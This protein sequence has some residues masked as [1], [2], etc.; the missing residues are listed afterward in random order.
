[1]LVKNDFY[2]KVE[3]NV[4]EYKLTISQEGYSR[5]SSSAPFASLLYIAAGMLAIP[6]IVRLRRKD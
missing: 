2:Y 5:P 3:S 6:V 4:L 1:M